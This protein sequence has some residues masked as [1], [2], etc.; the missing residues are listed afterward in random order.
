[1]TTIAIMV[2]DSCFNEQIFQLRQL[3]VE[4]QSAVLCHVIQDTMDNEW[5]RI[6]ESLLRDKV[7]LC[8]LML[9]WYIIENLMA[10]VPYTGLYNIRFITI[11]LHPSFVLNLQRN[12]LKIT[13]LRLRGGVAL[14]HIS[15]T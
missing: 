13:N 8:V 15:K 5:F 3:L 2:T 14:E 12:Y 4:G 10:R 7:I 11:E 9:P 1:M 6:T